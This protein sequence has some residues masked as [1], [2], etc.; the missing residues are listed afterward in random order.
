[1]A[2]IIFMTNAFFGF[3]PI[4]KYREDE[5]FYYFSFADN[6]AGIEE[7]LL[8]RIFERFY[9]INEGRT[10]DKGGSGLGLTIVKDA[11][12][13]HHGEIQARNRAGGGLEFL[14]TLRKY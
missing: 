6:G 2:E 12:A 11:V 5:D 10:R 7:K 1:M 3:N 8:E 14:F 13:F 4:Q 9:R